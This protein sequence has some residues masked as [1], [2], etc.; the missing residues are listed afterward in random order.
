MS[1]PA[2]PVTYCANHPQR[3]TRLRCNRCEKYICTECAVLTETGYRCKDCLR[4]Q[5]KVFKTATWVDY[6]L[7]MGVGGVLS[8]LGSLLISLVA[9]L[10]FFGFFT[11]LLA[12][13]AGGI[14]AEIV[15]RATRKRR[16]PGLFRW[17]AVAVAIGALPL[18]LVNLLA[19]LG[20]GVGLGGL[21]F[22]LIWQGA[23][24]FIVSTTVY[25]R[26][27]GIHLGR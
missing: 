23:Y 4:S 6:P 13:A 3:E 2:A 5:Q 21:L 26:L 14:I 15:R 22:P 19:V 27:S 12:P 7:A 1:G 24:A 11:L 9:S 16:S 17:T 20:L 8:F 18:V 10:G 25:Y